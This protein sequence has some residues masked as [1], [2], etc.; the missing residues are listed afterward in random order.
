MPLP[1]CLSA[2]R[3]GR[4]APST[5]RKAQGTAYVQTGDPRTFFNWPAALN[6]FCDFKA[7]PVAPIQFYEIV[8][9][10]ILLRFQNAEPLSIREIFPDK[11]TLRGFSGTFSLF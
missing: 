11:L 6:A 10:L 8:F 1:L 5:K 3:A 2:T 4:A 9:R 7:P